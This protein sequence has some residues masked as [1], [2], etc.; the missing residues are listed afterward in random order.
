VNS[1]TDGDA[2]SADVEST[3]RNDP[4]SG[5]IAFRH[6]VVMARPKLAF[7]LGSGISRPA[8]LPSLADLTE[9][10]LSA[11]DVYKGTDQVYYVDAEGARLSPPREEVAWVPPFL[12][13]VKCDVDRQRAEHGDDREASYEDLYYLIHQVVEHILGDAENAALAP[14]QD[15]YENAGPWRALRSYD[16]RP[17]IWRESR[18]FIH[19]L[20]SQ[21]L[22]KPT[23]RPLNYL[24]SFREAVADKAFSAVD[25]FTLNH[26]VVLEQHLLQHQV[27]VLDGFSSPPSGADRYWQRGLYEARAHTRLFKLHGSIN[28]W[29]VEGP[30]PWR[31]D[32]LTIPGSPVS[33]RSH[34][35]RNDDRPVL[36]I[37]TQNK[38]AEYTGSVFADLF[39]LFRSRLRMAD[40]LV[41][42]GYGFGDRGINRQI[43]EWFYSTSQSGKIAVLDPSS[44]LKQT[45]RGEIAHKWA[46]W[47]A[48]GRLHPFP[49]IGQKD[50]GGKNTESHK[51]A[52]W[53]DVRAYLLRQ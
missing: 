46:D 32:H 5:G 14:F 16:G 15:K 23:D 35:R 7:L 41:V 4:G 52:D 17:A 40:H 37:G 10:V 27:A 29:L 26:D 42:C 47:E 34:L 48:A 36:L 20:V 2:I 19:D 53:A 50:D 3:R 1:P 22:S 13:L 38:I 9:R 44:N 21:S 30:E 8:G 31:D 18:W 12:R 28:W 49:G 39:C 6:L 33:L 43:I 45:A 24:N 25:L 51:T 11:K